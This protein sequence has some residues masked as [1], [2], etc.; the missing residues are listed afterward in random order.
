MTILTVTSTTLGMK[1][2]IFAQCIKTQYRAVFLTVQNRANT[3]QKK[4]DNQAANRRFFDYKK[5]GLTHGV[6]P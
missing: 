2:T 1:T 3:L 6:Q 4:K 5:G